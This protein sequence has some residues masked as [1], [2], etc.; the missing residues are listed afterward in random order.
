MTRAETM[1]P[2]AKDK[3]TR[4]GLESFIF[5]YSLDEVSTHK[6]SHSQASL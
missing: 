1:E 3:A 4:M 6:A 2:R 5:I